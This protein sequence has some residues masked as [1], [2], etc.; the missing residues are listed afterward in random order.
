MIA[1][2][3]AMVKTFLDVFAMSDVYDR[4]D[5]LQMEFLGVVEELD[6]E[7]AAQAV[8]AL[9]DVARA[10]ESDL[11]RWRA[12]GDLAVALDL[13]ELLPVLVEGLDR[14]R[15]VHQL[16]NAIT[17]ASNPAVPEQQRQRVRD[18]VG[19]SGPPEPVRRMLD[20]RLGT[21]EPESD[22]ERALAAQVWPGKHTGAGTRPVVYVLQ[23]DADVRDVLRVMA[24]LTAAGA[25]TRRFVGTVGDAAVGPWAAATAPVVHWSGAGLARWRAA[26][27]AAHAPPGVLVSGGLA[28]PLERARLV[29]RV[30]EA[31]GPRQRLV[32]VRQNVS[33]L[34]SPFS[35]ETLHAG[36]YDFPEMSYLGATTR[37]G[38][39]RFAAEGLAPLA[40]DVQRWSFSQLV[41]V[42]I[43]QGFRA[44]G[45][46]YQRQAG[47]LVRKLDGIASASAV[48][49]VGLGA[50]GD[51]Y[52]DSG[53]GFRNERTGQ[54]AF[55][56]VLAV[57]QAFRPFNLGDGAVPDLLRP[58]RFTTVHPLTLG[59]T[60][61]I[62]EK[63]IG[64]R[65]LAAAS[66][67]MRI[68]VEILR[69][70]YPELSGPELADGLSVGEEILAKSYS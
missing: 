52:I 58:S 41:A 31:L 40:A 25:R 11:L 45:M 6:Q 54:Q 51:V 59:G 18:E 12:L 30:R 39:Q 47:E 22:L 19:R 56:G 17:L 4:L 20:I 68:S 9:A 10:L 70:A 63:R 65:S 48:H 34:P 15:D 37:H 1:I 61:C 62:E 46:R 26:T 36:A 38:L 7:E 57:D 24:I 23:A 53:D 49:R 55:D 33:D 14:Q 66:A 64:A 8:D 32:P 43:V 13:F 27:G 67:G 21:L 42:R 28:S 2:R 16:A 44:S 69:S 3:L 29:N 5:D 60:P 35:P 50:D